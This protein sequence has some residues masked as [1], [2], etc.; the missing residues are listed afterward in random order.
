MNK[1]LTKQNGVFEIPR[2]YPEEFKLSLMIH[3]PFFT[4]LLTYWIDRL[5]GLEMQGWAKGLFFVAIL[6]IF[7]FFI[8]KVKKEL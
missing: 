3:L 6:S 1:T 8:F 4:L 7:Y 2:L 5:F